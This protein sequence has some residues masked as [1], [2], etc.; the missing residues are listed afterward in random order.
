MKKFEKMTKKERLNMPYISHKK[1]ECL[2]KES[3]SKV[4]FIPIR[5]KQ[6]GYG[7]SATFIECKSGWYRLQDYDCFKFSI[8]CKK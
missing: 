6:S 8:F 1:L 5:R 2:K 3:V 4:V 7:M